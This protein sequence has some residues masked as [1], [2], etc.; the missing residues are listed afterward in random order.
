MSVYA[1]GAAPLCAN[2]ATSINTIM[3]LLED[4]LDGTIAPGATARTYGTLY[5]VALLYTYPDTFLYDEFN[6]RVAIRGDFDDFPIIE[7]S[8]YTQ[9]ASVISF[10]GGGGALVDGAKVKQPNCPFPGLELD[11]S[12]SFPNQGKSMAVSYTHLTLPTKRIV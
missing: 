6:T 9:N 10:L 4:V 11:G 5:D 2:V 3:A 7:A 8:P 12:A 1:A